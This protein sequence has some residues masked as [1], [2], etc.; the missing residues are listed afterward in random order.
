[1]FKLFSTAFIK[2][3]RIQFIA[4]LGSLLDIVSSQSIHHILILLGFPY[5]TSIAFSYLLPVKK[6]ISKK[7]ISEQYRPVKI[8]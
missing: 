8:R 5:L 7:R 3:Q 6:T 2:N 4:M 1:M